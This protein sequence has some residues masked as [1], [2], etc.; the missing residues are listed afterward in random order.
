MI[1]FV[2]QKVVNSFL[3]SAFRPPRLRKGGG[4]IKCLIYAVEGTPGLGEELKRE[5]PRA[6]AQGAESCPWPLVL[7]AG[8]RARGPE[9]PRE[10]GRHLSPNSGSRRFKRETRQS[11]RSPPVF[12][13][14]SPC[15]HP[16]FPTRGAL[17]R[18]RELDLSEGETGWST[19]AVL[20]S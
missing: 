9:L 11:A 6:R 4:G 19:S 17:F 18:G 15:H 1:C 3:H 13:L 2:E 7:K 12:S 10:K 5:G 20:C 8:V 16:R 14:G